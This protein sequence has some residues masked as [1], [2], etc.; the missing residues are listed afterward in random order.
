MDFSTREVPSREILTFKLNLDFCITSLSLCF[1][2]CK[3]EIKNRYPSPNIVV[4]IMS[5]NVCKAFSAASG[6]QLS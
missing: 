3:I 4:K 2:L 5:D 6:T 1:L